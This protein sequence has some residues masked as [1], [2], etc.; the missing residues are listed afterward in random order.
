MK[1][2]KLGLIAVVVMFLNNPVNAQMSAN[3]SEIGAKIR[4]MGAT[5]N[6]GLIMNTYKLYAPLLK[7]APKDGVKVGLNQ[8]Y[9]PHE[10]HLLDVY[11]PQSNS[12]KLPILVF[13]HG[14][15]FVRGDKKGYG[16]VGT[17][18]ARNG[19][20]G[21]MANYRLAPKN[22]WPSGAEDIARIIKWIKS[23]GAKFGGDSN[24]IFL[25]GNSAGTGHIAS[26]IFFEKY[27]VKGDGVKGA[28]L[29]SGPTYELSTKLTPKGVLGHPGERAYFGVD[30]SKY[31]NM[32][33][34]RNIGGRKIPVFIAYAEL[35]M[36]MIQ[37]QN[38]LLIDAIFKRDRL[39]PTVK[40][41]LGH[42]HISIISHINTKDD[43]I[44]S[45]TLEFIKIRSTNM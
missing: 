30:A 18:M 40:Q 3:P 5:I 19:L 22:K 14:G 6:R 26:Y 4:A 13:L 33:S 7:K 31:Q 20:V 9:G 16:N 42:N 39:L 2:L 1:T 45:D 32:S 17:Y 23:N 41:V 24:N 10:R 44:G 29:V 8:S 35:D 36:P 43:S 15:G 37:H 34:I 27:Q 25:M 28:I 38:L 21:I 12:E 11:Q